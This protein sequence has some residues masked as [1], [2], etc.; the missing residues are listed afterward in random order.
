MRRSPRTP[1]EQTAWESPTGWA[2]KPEQEKWEY[3]T[4][5]PGELADYGKGGWEAYC[6]VVSQYGAATIYLKRKLKS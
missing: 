1:T 5:S 6:A 2:A 4:A 3:K